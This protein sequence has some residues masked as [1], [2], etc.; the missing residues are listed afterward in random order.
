MGFF[1]CS[2]GC[3]GGSYWGSSSAVGDVLEVVI[4]VPLPWRCVRGS[5]WDS[6][7]AVGIIG[8]LLGD[9]CR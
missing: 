8:V 2:G 5:Y 7:S 3:V 1:F 6:S 9:G 4:G